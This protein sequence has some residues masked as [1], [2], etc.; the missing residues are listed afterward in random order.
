MDL[1]AVGGHDTTDIIYSNGIRCG[2]VEMG[3]DIVRCQM[4]RCCGKVINKDQEMCAAH[5]TH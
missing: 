1:S 5:E 2:V 4:P 3:D